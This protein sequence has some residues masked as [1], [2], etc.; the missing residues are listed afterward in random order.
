VAYNQ[1]PFEMPYQTLKLFIKSGKPVQE[2]FRGV[3][4]SEHRGTW[5]KAVRTAMELVHPKDFKEVLK[6]MSLTTERREL[7]EYIKELLKDDI[8]Q[9]KH[10]SEL[11][12]LRKTAKQL[13]AEGIPIPTIS[14]C[15]GLSE[16]EIKKLV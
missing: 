2:V 10:D 6:D 14:K 3:L 12:A 1:L 4:E 15:T 16:D 8:E 11:N 7:R 5:L 9:E 13:L